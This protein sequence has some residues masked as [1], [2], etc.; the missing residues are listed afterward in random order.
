MT[1]LQTKVT[2]IGAAVLSIINTLAGLGI[3]LPTGVD[4]TGVQLVSAAVM[5]IAAAVLH[6]KGKDAA[7]P[8]AA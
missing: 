2:A 3:G 5:A 4:A 7:I 8:P 6:F 1:D